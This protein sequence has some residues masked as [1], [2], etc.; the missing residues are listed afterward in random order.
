MKK[1]LLISILFLSGCS[2]Y[3]NLFDKVPETKQV[4]IL[5]VQEPA[6][7]YHPP[8][9]EVLSPSEIKWKV[10]NPETMRTYI[11]DYDKG[12]AP[13]VAYYSL[14]SQGYENL[15]NNIADIKRYIRQSLTIIEYY[16]DND[17]TKNKENDNE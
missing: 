10:L 3:G 12:D 5:T 16:R 7:I 2:T 8:L 17:P 14:T 15:S 6:P 1:L 11:E 9:P 4:E 13:A